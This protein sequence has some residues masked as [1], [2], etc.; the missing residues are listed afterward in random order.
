MELVL[1]RCARRDIEGFGVVLGVDSL[2]YRGGSHRRLGAIFI[3]VLVLSWTVFIRVQG[4][5]CTNFH[6]G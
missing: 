4:L 6:R 5:V 3:I 1:E 2:M